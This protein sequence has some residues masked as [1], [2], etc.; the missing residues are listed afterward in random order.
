MPDRKQTIRA[1]VALSFIL[2]AGPARAQVELLSRTH[3]TLIPDT[4]GG[5]VTSI[6]ADGRFVVLESYNGNILSER[7]TD[8]G[9]AQVYLYD[10]QTGE[11]TLVSRTHNSATTGGNNQSNSGVLSA[12]GRFVVYSSHA[13]DLVAGLVKPFGS[14]ANLFLY[15]RAAGT[16]VLVSHSVAS[17]TTV[18]NDYST[19]PVISADGRYV[20]FAS[21]AED[22]VAGQNDS[23]SDSDIF[24]YDRTSGTSV[25]VSHTPGAPTTSVRGWLPAISA[26]GAYIT[27]LSYFESASG[28]PELYLYETASGTISRV[29]RR[30][31]DPTM[32]EQ[33][34][35]GRAVL[36]AEGRII[37]FTSPGT[38]LVSGQAEDAEDA[39]TDDVFVFDRV[40]GTTVLASR[41]AVSA[42]T[43]GD[44]DSYAPTLSAD[45]RFVAFVSKA[46]DLV[47]GQ[48]DT[49]GTLDVFLHDLTLGSTVLVSRQS[50]D[51]PTVAHG[52]SHSPR[53]SADGSQ[54]VFARESFYSRPF[55]Q[56]SFY[57]P[58]LYLFERATGVRRWISHPA[59]E[60]GGA[61]RAANGAVINGDGTYV[62]YT[63]GSTD[64]VAGLLDT[65]QADDAFLYNR[66]AESNTLLTRRDPA[67][68]DLTPPGRS[69]TPLISSDGRFVAYVSSA[70]MIVP[71][72]ETRHAE[73]LYLLDQQ[74]GVTVPVAGDWIDRL[75]P[76]GISADGR[77]LTFLSSSFD[78]FPGQIDTF[79]SPDVFSYDRI[80][81]TITLL[82]RTAASPVTGGSQAQ[83]I[84]VTPDGRYVSFLS[85]AG[86]LVPGQVDVDAGLNAFLHD[87]VTGLTELV[88]HAIGAPAG[89]ANGET[90]S[91]AVSADGR[92]VA[93]VSSATDLVAGVSDA[94]G[95]PDLFLHDRRTGATT[96]LSQASGA[97][98]TAANGASAEPAFS[99]NGRCLVFTSEATDLLPG[100]D[101]YWDVFNVFLY[102]LVT[103]Q[104]TL[105]SHTH[106][107][108]TVGGT[109]DSFAPSSSADC[110]A[111]TYQSFAEDL[112]AEP[113]PAPWRL[114]L[115]LAEPVLGTTTLLAQGLSARGHWYSE[116]V[117]SVISDNGRF[118]AFVTRNDLLHGG[119]DHPFPNLY[120]FDRVT[121]EPVLVSRVDG[122]PETPG[123]WESGQLSLSSDGRFIAFYSLASN[124][125]PGIFGGGNVFLFDN[126]LVMG[127]DFYTLA[128]C[129]LLDT[130]RPEDGPAL[131]SGAPVIFEVDGG[132]GIPEMARALALNV[133]VFNPT[134]QG[135]LSLGPGDAAPSGTSSINFLPGMNRANNAIV[136][137]SL[138]GSAS[139]G[140]RP[141]VVGGGTVHVILDV[142]GWFE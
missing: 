19:D 140:V 5:S 48:N 78:L 43:P 135:N 55:P 110:S 30:S 116:D 84:R 80:A 10:R 35:W 115:V 92:Y 22:L 124:L 85:P 100:L 107:S 67:M 89:E 129:R 52:Y 37:A 26:D 128:P 36:S 82:S 73:T 17:P 25:L 71:G 122:S 28:Y 6:S 12:D 79:L 4:A 131:T 21:P 62:A 40:S 94:N 64:L 18:A 24:L 114:A 2:C 113:G 142:V 49:A 112:F 54:I 9:M 58:D 41:S 68:P 117:P 139:I 137:L 47:A 42:S 63:S 134:G 136:P 106:G 87:R 44:R 105:V 132:C 46:M 108:S 102:S 97:P 65:N 59:G 34:S 33:V 75:M 119:A 27:F 31:D 16:N 13:S 96:L 76:L 69:E 121:R 20:A 109:G 29:S 1:V 81:G 126:E 3:P 51:I 45:G 32:G 130:R 72:F 14:G 103:G 90:L 11:R 91:A 125:V 111:I 83:G 39:V 77:F 88:S 15:D 38:H 56:Q 57:L 133:T 141:L 95:A 70:S 98:G 23:Y 118:A 86:N 93:W 138:D 66:S 99:A 50:D 8:H 120:F 60:P 7:P 101:P 53:I 127:G 123:N 74:S 104:T 61:I